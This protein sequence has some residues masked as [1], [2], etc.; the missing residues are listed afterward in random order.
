VGLHPPQ[1]YDLRAKRAAA[2]AATK[3]TSDTTAPA[4]APGGVYVRETR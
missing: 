2:A 3:E 4:R 1:S